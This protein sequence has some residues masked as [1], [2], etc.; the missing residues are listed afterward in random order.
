MPGASGAPG[1]FYIDP[2]IA[3]WRNPV[4]QPPVDR[5]EGFSRERTARVRKGILA[6]SRGRGEAGQVARPF[7]TNRRKILLHSGQNAPDF[8]LSTVDGQ[9]ISLGERLEGKSYLLLVFLRHLG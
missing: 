6:A 3:D 7:I 9:R 4:W 5:A 1:T 2:F 8:E